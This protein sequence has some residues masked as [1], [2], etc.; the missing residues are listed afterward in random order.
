MKDE[1]RTI[2]NG[3]FSDDGKE[4]NLLIVPLP[5]LCNSCL[6]FNK[7]TEEIPCLLNRMDQME[8]IRRGE[9]FCCFA[10]ELI[11]SPVDK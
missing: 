5:S 4:I 2:M 7:A 1:S 10:Y 11:D 8:E 9:M 6:K 3:Y